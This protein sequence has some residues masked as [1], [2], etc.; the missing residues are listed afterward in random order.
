[1]KKLII[2]AASLVLAVV[3]ANAQMTELV[4]STGPFQTVGSGARLGMGSMMQSGD[5][6]SSAMGFNGALE[7]QYTYYFARKG[8]NAPYFG[9]RSGLSISYLQNTVKQGK[10]E[11]VYTINADKH[12]LTYSIS[13]NSL[14]EKN[15]QLSVEVPL[16]ATCMYKQLF[17]SLGVKA[18]IPM[19]SKYNLTMSDPMTSVKV[20]DYGV[21]IDNAPV[22]GGFSESKIDVKDKLDASTFNMSI[23]FEGGYTMKFM[24]NWLSL[25]LYFDYG[26]VNNF[27]AGDG[28]I[29]K[30]DMTTINASTQTPATVSVESMTK[31]LADKMGNMDFGIRAIYSWPMMNG[32]K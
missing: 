19:M 12:N 24:N 8:K 21:Q 7:G 1:M 17:F 26:I 16:M 14:E 20:E 11:E 28:K 29:V 23:A 18:G 25:G 22:L 2:S 27:S 3:C 15:R 30:I 31:T 9:V 32:K 4:S 6:L 10:F 5:D 13:A